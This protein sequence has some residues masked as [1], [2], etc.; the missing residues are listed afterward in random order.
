VRLVKILLC[1]V[2]S[3][4]CFC[5]C[6][7]NHY[8]TYY[9]DTEG[10]RKVTSIHGAAPVI[11]KPTT[12]EEDVL[13]LMEDGYVASG[14]SSFYGPYTPMSLAVDTATKHGAALVLLDVRF[15]EEK[16]YTSVMYLP[17]FSTSYNSGTVHAGGKVGNYS[18]TTTTTTMNAVPVQKSVEIYTHD[19]MYFKKADVSKI[20]GVRYWVPKRLPTDPIDGPIK[21]KV[22]A[23][24]HGTRAER[25]GIKR[26]QIVKSINGVEIKT[27]KDLSLLDGE[28]KK[29]E[30]CDAE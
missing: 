7:T 19:A 30:V 6:L 25:D 24:V 8:E 14:V 1:S 12:T 10:A 11:V 21:V 27:R 17:S 16:Q 29:M 26:G 20:Y 18:G 4:C 23:V 5:G 15:K 13:R 3:A 28:I 9:V 22:I 2:L